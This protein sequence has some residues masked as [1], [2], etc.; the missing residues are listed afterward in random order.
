VRWIVA[1]GTA[2]AG[3]PKALFDRLLKRNHESAG[4]KVAPCAA[5]RAAG[6]LVAFGDAK[7]AKLVNGNF[8]RHRAEMSG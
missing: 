6:V 2:L 3:L 4:E 5:V 7:R 8:R 1:A